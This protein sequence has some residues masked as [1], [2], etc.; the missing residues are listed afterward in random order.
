MRSAD[1]S[2]SSVPAVK[3]WSF[4]GGTGAGAGE[5]DTDAADIAIDSR[6]NVLIADTG[7]HRVV[8][9]DPMGKSLAVSVEKG[10]ATVNS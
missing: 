10:G 7:N 4:S 8:R 5:F 2:I 1:V 9:F 3:S 6:G